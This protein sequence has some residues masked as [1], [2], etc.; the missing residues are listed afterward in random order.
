MNFTAAT[1]LTGA[2]TFAGLTQ[3][4]SGNAAISFQNPTTIATLNLSSGVLAGAGPVTI[5]GTM[6]WTGGGITG[7]LVI[8]AKA[9]LQINMPFD[10]SFYLAGGTI[11][12]SG[13]VSQ[14]FA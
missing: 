3:I 6:N 2:Y 1:E 12:N 7:T 9:T 13:T 14:S 10:A 4:Q 5:T 8:P 11:N